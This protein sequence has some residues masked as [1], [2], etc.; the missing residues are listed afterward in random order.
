MKNKIK[1]V[2]YIFFL[3]YLFSFSIIH[4]DED[5]K[6]EVT[7]LE[8]VENGN[9]IIGTK[10][11]LI[12]TDNG[13][14]LEANEFIYNKI[15]NILN[16]SGNVVINDKIN[17]YLINSD[18][19][20]YNKKIDE[21]TISQN[22]IIKY[23]DLTIKGDKIIYDRIKNI[24]KGNGNIV[25][26]DNNKDYTINSE[27]IIYK[28]AEEFI[29]SEGE[30]LALINSKYNFNSKDVSLL[31]NEGLISSLKD[32]E[33]QDNK[34]RIYNF[35][36]FNFNINNNTLKAENIEIILD[37]TIPLTQTDRLKFSN[38][39]INLEKQDFIASDTE[40]RLKKDIFNNQKNDPRLFG[41]SSKKEANITSVNKGIFT[42]CSQEKKNCTPWKIKAKKIEHNKE[43]QKIIYDHAVL[44]IYD[45][46]VLYFPKFFH[47]DPS[48]KRQSGFLQPRLNNSNIIGNSLN[49]PYFHILSEN[50]DITVSP[51][52]FD[53]EINMIQNEYRQVNKDSIFFADF[54]FVNNYNI[55][56]SNKKKNIYHLFS[57]FD[58][59]LKLKNHKT[60]N[61]SLFL[62]RVNKDNFLRVFESNLFETPVSPKDKN[63]LYSGINLDMNNDQYFLNSGFSM[64]ENLNLNNNDRYQYNLPY[65]NFSKKV[66]AD[67][68]WLLNFYSSGNNTLVETNNLKSTIVNDLTIKKS[69]DKK[70]FKNTFNLDFKNLN[71][72][73]KK[74][75]EYSSKIVNNL[76]NI[77]GLDSSIP[78][79]KNTEKYTNLLTP[80]FTYR[81]NI[82]DSK[83]KNY[84]SLNRN[85][86]LNN[87]FA[88][89]RLGI[90][91]NFEPGESITLGFEY[92]SLNK[93]NET[94]LNFSLAQNYRSKYEDKIPLKT[95]LGD[96][97]S[98]LFGLIKYDTSN[99]FNID[100]NFAIDN[101]LETI[102][103]S[104][105]NFNFELESFKTKFN[106]IRENGIMG[107]TNLIENS[108]VFNFDDNNQI[109]F[110]SRRNR[111]INLT[112][113]YDLVYEYKNDCLAAGIK[114]NK[115]YYEDRE[116]KPSENL[117]FTISIFPIS[118]FEQKVDQN[119]Y[120]N[121]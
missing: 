37:K 88:V 55:K 42:S 74:N 16:V 31:R 100:Y 38:G 56:N 109:S 81:K 50:K 62:E 108:S 34:N 87:I 26:R 70:G 80:K 30:T 15:S 40:I 58:K 84:Y 90:D 96:K 107:D 2:I 39:F 49:V 115:T 1:K 59:D 41:I 76:N 51:S 95:S 10:R 61:L 68:L 91:D 54:G 85:I 110:K 7:E 6:F 4:A 121:N 48:V 44:H 14:T 28:R 29:F 71:A 35:N 53:N 73:G 93:I 69:F 86:D 11:G 57:K 117:M 98:S 113:F 83:N 114:Y 111:K 106:I 82:Y 77:F 5:F 23:N 101:K 102:Q 27:N 75:N 43:K 21:V 89:N 8:I 64:Y 25:I 9:K 22:S 13:L 94:K 3:S 118:T 99:M 97:N 47:P 63:I 12:E 33:I 92:E 32:T 120:R 79:I 112:E 20:T 105:L 116:I 19:A 24:F 119:F 103:F 36:N 67:E 45:K 60:S 78:L 66:Y 52:I 65:Y 72:T 46:P 104:S 17:N 18:F